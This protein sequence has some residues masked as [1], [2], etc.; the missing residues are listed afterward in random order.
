MKPLSSYLTEAQKL[1][2][3]DS[4]GKLL[5][6]YTMFCEDAKNFHITYSD[7]DRQVPELLNNFDVAI[8]SFVGLLIAMEGIYFLVEKL[9][10]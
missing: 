3:H 8:L 4:E 2:T 6:H 9:I 7:N 10:S 5:D 1:P